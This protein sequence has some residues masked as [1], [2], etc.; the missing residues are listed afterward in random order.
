MRII[1]QIIAVILL[2]WMG[3]FTQLSTSHMGH[4]H[5]LLPAEANL[6]AIDCE[7]ESHHGAGEACQWFKYANGLRY[8]D[9]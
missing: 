6:C 3:V 1:N 5:D 8:I 9:E 2:G 7:E 4:G